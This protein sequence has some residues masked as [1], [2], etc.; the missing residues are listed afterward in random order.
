MENGRVETIEEFLE[1]GGV[2]RKIPEKQVKKFITMRFAG[3][4]FRLMRDEFNLIGTENY[5]KSRIPT[6]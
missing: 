5:Q 1:R 2:I 4:L 3:S 6:H